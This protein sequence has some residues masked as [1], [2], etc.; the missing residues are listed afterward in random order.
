ML[1]T[2]EAMFQVDGKSDLDGYFSTD[3]VVS[4]GRERLSGESRAKVE[5]RCV[6]AQMVRKRE[7]TPWMEGQGGVFIDVRITGQACLWVVR[8]VCGSG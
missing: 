8:G 5:R 7:E 2:W 1:E 3:R 4:A 6:E